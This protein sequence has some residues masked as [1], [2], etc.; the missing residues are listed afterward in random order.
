M[1]RSKMVTSGFCL[2]RAASRPFQL[3]SLTCLL[4]LKTELEKNSPL[5]CLHTHEHD[6]PLIGLLT[7][8]H[9]RTNQITF[10]N[11]QAY[12]RNP[13]QTITF[14]PQGT[15]HSLTLA[16]VSRIKRTC[17]CRFFVQRERNQRELASFCE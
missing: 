3:F 14:W 15:N 9:P 5:L 8:F 12:R 11:A 4:F 7:T 1:I 2:L 6:M 16:A 17:F 13:I 10:V